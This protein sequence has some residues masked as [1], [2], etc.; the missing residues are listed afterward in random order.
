MT[1]FQIRCKLNGRGIA[2]QKEG[3]PC[4]CPSAGECRMLEEWKME[5]QEKSDKKFVANMGTYLKANGLL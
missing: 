1:S 5:E 4:A 3:G 2:M